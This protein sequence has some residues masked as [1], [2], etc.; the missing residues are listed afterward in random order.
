V[1]RAANGQEALDVV[2]LGKPTLVLM[3]LSMPVLDGWEATR[4]IK[5]DVAT[6]DVI[7]VAVTGH[8][9]EEGLAR[10]RAAGADAVLTKPWAP[11]VILARVRAL[12]DQL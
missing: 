8:G 1:D 10:A 7:V 2:A 4:R 9:T 12:L 3:D 11:N 5:T 6:R